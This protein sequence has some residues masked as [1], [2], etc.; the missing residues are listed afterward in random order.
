MEGGAVNGTTPS[1][2]VRLHGRRR[3]FMAVCLLVVLTGGVVSHQ[4]S[5]APPK[6]LF[7]Q[8]LEALDRGDVA[9]ARVILGRMSESGPPTD[10]ARILKAALSAKSMD[11]DGVIAQLTPLPSSRDLEPPARL[12]LTEA[13]YR[14]SQL[15]EAR[16]VAAALVR[17]SPESAGGWRWLA[18]IDYDAGALEDAL[19]AL[20]Q[21]SRLAPRDYQ[22]H[23]LMGLVYKD[24][25]RYPQAVEALKVALSLAPPATIVDEVR[26]DLAQSLASL[27]Q[28]QESLDV[29]Q[30][31]S[32][33]P[34]GI[35]LQVEALW[36]LG[37]NDE[38]TR[39]LD[40]VPSAMRDDPQ[41]LNVQATIHLDQRRPAE[42][43]AVLESL[44][45]SDPHDFRSRYRLASAYGQLEDAA[46]QKQE[47]ALA[48]AS[49]SLRARLTELTTKAIEE[50]RN[51]EVRRE[52][53][54]VCEQLG[55]KELARMWKAAAESR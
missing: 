36:N 49:Q 18:A 27:N 34:R 23:R 25:E 15:M 32:G 11:W 6:R 53:A 4:W 35:A 41:I 7:A 20:Q 47:L 37:R 44:L 21:V 17:A 54:Q 2:Q 46:R 26:G 8:G 50:P 1:H 22:P 51:R 14:S 55:K 42:A 19:R 52:L 39:L 28:W 43:A 33:S 29:A 12:L 45:K 9:T 5:S 16:A 3:V 24:F 10:E 30:R 48:E 13:L 31:I 40:G 38:A